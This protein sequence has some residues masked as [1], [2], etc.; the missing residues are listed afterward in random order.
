MALISSYPAT[1]TLS[2]DDYFLINGDTSG[3]RRISGE[4][5]SGEM[6]R[7]E[8]TL[9]AYEEIGSIS[10]GD[11]ILMITGGGVVG[12]ITFQTLVEAVETVLGN[13][14]G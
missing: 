8:P 10:D 12:K 6:K 5:L 4:N 2:D 3:T 7:L 9:D 14:E 1:S 11:F 13:E